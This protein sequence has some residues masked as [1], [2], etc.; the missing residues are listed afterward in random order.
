MTGHCYVASEAVF[1]LLGGKA[2]GLKPASVAHEG[3]THWWLV[4]TEGQ[5]IDPTADQFAT[6]VPYERGRCRGFLT[7]EPSARAQE[8]LRLVH[9]SCSNGSART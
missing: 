6:P 9:E 8:V 7:R 5:V 4:T 1:A 2:A 3:S